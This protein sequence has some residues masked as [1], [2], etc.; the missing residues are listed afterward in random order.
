MD[1]YSY[2]FRSS[3]DYRRQIRRKATFQ[4][5]CLTMA[6]Q[7]RTRF[8]ILRRRLRKIMI[9]YLRLHKPEDDSSSQIS[10]SNDEMNLFSIQQS[11]R[12]CCLCNNQR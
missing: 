2:L 12:R 1:T 4:K 6:K 8:Y 5:R 11:S 10:S 9:V 7:E 3:T